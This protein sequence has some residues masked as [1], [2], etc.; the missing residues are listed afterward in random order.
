MNP[1]HGFYDLAN[2]VVSILQ[3]IMK[4]KARQHIREI[5]KQQRA[6]VLAGE[7]GLKRRG[8]V[9]IKDGHGGCVIWMCAAGQQKGQHHGHVWAYIGGQ[10]RRI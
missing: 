9:T 6:E 4:M 5:S 3:G 8:F 2:L 10:S 1:C 7:R